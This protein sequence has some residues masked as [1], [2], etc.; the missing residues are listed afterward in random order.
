MVAV[1]VFLDVGVGIDCYCH[2][3]DYSG[4]G[5]YFEDSTDYHD[6]LDAGA[7]ILE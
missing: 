5:Y 3:S 2:C 1:L 7:V 4:D 6:E